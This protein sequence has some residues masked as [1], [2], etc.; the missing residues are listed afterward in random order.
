MLRRHSSYFTR[1][2]A[3]GPPT[4]TPPETSFSERFLDGVER[5]TAAAQDSVGPEEALRAIT[6]ACRDLLGDEEAQYRPG[7]LKPGEHQFSAAGAFF[8]T[9]D[10][11]FN[12]LL[13]EV[14]FPVEQHRLK[15]DVNHI[16]FNLLPGVV[17]R[18][19]SRG[20]SDLP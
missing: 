2:F 1:S 6:L 19:E 7:A 10:R 4:M 3:T 16:N 5:A 9:P 17:V 20:G 11:A 8:V 14:N 18:L 13:A 15:I 12:L